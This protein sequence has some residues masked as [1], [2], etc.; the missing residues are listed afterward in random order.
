[1]LFTLLFNVGCLSKKPYLGS[2]IIAQNQL[3][4]NSI[5]NIQINLYFKARNQIT[6]IIILY[7]YISKKSLVQIKQ[8]RYGP[9]SRLL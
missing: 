2:F 9:V 8:D 5:I 3:L 1:M 4:L 6:C 7:A